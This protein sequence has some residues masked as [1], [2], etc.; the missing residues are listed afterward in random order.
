MVSARKYK[1]LKSQFLGLNL[2]SN[3]VGTTTNATN[4]GTAGTSSA[5]TSEA[6]GDKSTDDDDKGKL[7]M[8]GVR[9]VYHHVKYS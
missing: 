7:L 5:A 3:Y 2:H 1:S 4:S 8:P 6:A 9:D